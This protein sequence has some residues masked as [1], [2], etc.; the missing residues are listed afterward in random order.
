MLSKLQRESHCQD[1]SRGQHRLQA[2]PLRGL[3]SGHAPCGAVA[4]V[5]GALVG[6]GAGAGLVYV[7]DLAS[8]LNE[9]CH[10]LFLETRHM[11]EY[12][13]SWLVTERGTGTRN[14]SPRWVVLTTRARE[15]AG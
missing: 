8:R 5:P 10:L 3:V 11:I 4:G 6:A 13:R 12:A 14:D 15:N 9:G 1:L 7:F 2:T